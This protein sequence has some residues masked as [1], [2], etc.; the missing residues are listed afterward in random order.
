MYHKIQP[1]CQP[2]RTVNFHKKCT[3]ALQTTRN[4]THNQLAMEQNNTDR[5]DRTK[6][7]FANVQMLLMPEFS[8]KWNPINFGFRY[9][10]IGNKFDWVIDCFLIGEE[11]R[12]PNHNSNECRVFLSHTTEKNKM[13]GSQFENEMLPTTT[14]YHNKTRIEMAKWNVCMLF[15]RRRFACVLRRE[16]VCVHA[17]NWDEHFVV[18]YTLNTKT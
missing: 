12:K 16:W 10:P 18:K 5:I 17:C 4:V 3:A 1:K 11:K 8:L 15:Q 14:M 2:I 13:S 6:E 7:N 9:T